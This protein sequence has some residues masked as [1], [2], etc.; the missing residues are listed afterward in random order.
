MHPLCHD[1][2][3]SA[4]LQFKQSFTIEESA[5]S[6]PIA[7]GRVKSWTLGENSTDCCSWDGVD[8]VEDTGHVIG[9]D[10]NS[11]CRQSF[12]NDTSQSSSFYVFGPDP[13]RSFKVV[14]QLSSLG[15]GWN[16]DSK[17]SLL[18]LGRLSLT[19]LVENLTLLED[20]DL[21][22]VSI[23][24]TVPNIFATM[25]NLRSLYLFDCGMYG[26]FP[27]GIFMLPNLRILDV[28]HNEDLNGSWPDFQY[29]RSPLEQS[30][31]FSS[32]LPSS[33][34]NLSSLIALEMPS[35]NL[36]GSIPS[37]IGNLTNLIYLDLSNNILVGNIPS[38]IENFI[39]LGLLCLHNNHL[40]GLI[41]SRLANLTLL[42]ILDMSYNQLTSPIP[43]GLRKLT[44]LNELGLAG[45]EFEGKFPI[46]IFN[47]RNLNF[48]DISNNYLGGIKWICNMTFLH[49]LDVSNNNF[50]GSLPE[51]LHNMF[52]GSKL[53]MISLRGNKFQG[54]LPRSLANCTM[55][56]A[57]DVSNNQ[58]SDTFL[59]WLENLPNLEILILRSNQFYGKILESPETNYEFPN[60]RILDLSYNIFTGNL[61]LNSFRN[62]NALKLDK[63]DHPLTYIHEKQYFNVGTHRLYYYYDYSMKITN[64]GMDTVYNKAQHFFRA[65]DMSS[66]RFVGEIPKSIGDLKELNM[67]N[68]SNNFLT[69]HIPVSLGN[70]T[71]LESLDFSQNRLSGEIP[72]QLTQLTFLEWFNVSHNYLSGSIP[73]GNQFNTFETS[74]FEGNLGLCGNPLSKKCWDFGSSPAVFDRSLDSPGF[75]F[76]FGWKIVFVGYG[77]GFIVG[78]IIGNIATTRKDDRLKKAFE[79]TQS[80]TSTV[81]ELEKGTYRN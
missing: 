27:K 35:C 2:E 20:L 56:E 79:M 42:I 22:R 50:N 16:R 26:D 41:P 4:L 47:L 61:P 67:L 68:L 70:L 53:R 80:T 63:H 52:S 66:N 75:H 38:S 23:S 24:S 21:S 28:N 44:L 9:L 40:T 36:L 33:K 77:F 59:S 62:W 7:C 12:E 29:W 64:K 11:S 1:D 37:S 18:Q 49:V 51:C 6:F 14:L 65:I 81:M 30:I 39:Q 55:L 54:L 73:E 76:E 34:G 74:S 5:S 8:C 48:L 57:F 69:R 13:I 58:F 10:L 60:L 72:P 31:N 15:L 19:S 25:S 78:V 43:L 71:Q 45:N 3:R 17:K 46:F 32:E